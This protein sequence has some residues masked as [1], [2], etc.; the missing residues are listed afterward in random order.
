MCTAVFIEGPLAHYK[1]IS[2]KSG[3]QKILLQYKHRLHEI[4]G[5]F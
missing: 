3:M 4:Y 2:N 5:P 1:W